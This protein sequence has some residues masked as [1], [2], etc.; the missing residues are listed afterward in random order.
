V[1]ASV[2]VSVEVWYEEGCGCDLGSAKV[3]IK[4]MKRQE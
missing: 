4:S 3:E 2:G 1:G